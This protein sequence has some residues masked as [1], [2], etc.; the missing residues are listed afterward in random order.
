MQALDSL[1]HRALD[2]YKRSQLL[3][4]REYRRAS[5]WQAS[6][7]KA[8]VDAA[9]T[10]LHDIQTKLLV[11][12]NAYDRLA[13]IGEDHYTRYH[14]PGRYFEVASIAD[15]AP[16]RLRVLKTAV[17]SLKRVAMLWSANSLNMP[18]CHELSLATATELGISVQLLGVRE[19]DDFDGAFAS[20]EN[21]MPEGLVM[22]ADV[23][24]NLNRRRMYTFS[25]AH[26]L[27]TIYET[28]VYA[29]E[30]GLMSYG[31][32]AADVPLGLTNHRQPTQFRLVFNLNTAQSIN[33]TI[34]PNLIAQ[35]DEV[36]T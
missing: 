17:P 18:W 2:I 34:P 20:M 19:P 12:A 11:I 9:L 15:P 22:A 6:A 13:V 32:D 26:K 21:E 5:Y 16:E 7:T 35:A 33:L 29:R 36:I 10:S 27:P 14:E 30:G 23:L 28:A 25:R 1:R 8:R 31:P 24:G 4:E 3:L